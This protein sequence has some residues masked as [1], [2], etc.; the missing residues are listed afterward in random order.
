MAEKRR[1]NVSVIL[2][3]MVLQLVALVSLVFVMGCGASRPTAPLP[4]TEP[5]STPVRSRPRE[6]EPTWRLTLTPLARSGRLRVVV[7]TPQ[8]VRWELPSRGTLHAT[9]VTPRRVSYDLEPA[10]ETTCP[11]EVTP[12]R[13]VICGSEALPTPDEG[14]EVDIS[15]RLLADESFYPAAASS[16]GVGR[17]GVV[18]ARFTDLHLAGFVFGDVHH[19]TFDAEVGRDHAAWV[20]FFSF[21]PRWVA[22]E[23]A[24]VRTAVDRWLGIARPEDDPSVGLLLSGA[25]N[26]RGSVAIRPLRRGALVQ[27][28]PSA[29][30]GA[31]SRIDLTRLWVQRTLGHA[32][33]IDHPEGRWW[34]DEGVA[35]GVAV[36][37][38][39]TLGVLTPEEVAGELNALLAQ[40]AFADEETRAR[41]AAVRGALFAMGLQGAEGRLGGALR[42]LVAESAGRGVAV[43]D[44]D[45]FFAMLR[46]SEPSPHV[47]RLVDAFHGERP[48]PVRAID[49]G[50]CARLARRTVH[51]FELGLSVD[52]DGGRVAI[53]TA[54]SAAERAGVRAGD[55]LEA[56][57]YEPGRG[58]VPVT[59][60]VVR[61]GRHHEISFYPRGPGRRAP[62][63]TIVPG[64][65]A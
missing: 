23:A 3:G 65:E 17:G 31:R 56:I 6:V 37:V 26:L 51:R 7:D 60:V 9:E 18:R 38:L 48:I 36:S 47:Q 14:D 44:S 58:E 46:E 55:A 59:L 35:H 15:I 30:W 40:Q 63:L 52:E 11:F 25:A 64:C 16:Y 41:R 2:I 10:S 39:R 24:G 34:F 22:A 4:V 20:G 19:A 43:V 8:P 57:D 50:P 62:A 45:A 27:A 32:L 54:G 12:D 1:R 61:E 29:Y 33:T 13:A 21:D 28:G 5:P 42:R 53:V 49:A